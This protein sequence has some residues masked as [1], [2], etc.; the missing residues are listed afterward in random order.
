MS[1]QSHVQYTHVQSVTVSS[2]R[3]KA[4]NK[5]S[6]VSWTAECEPPPP[7]CTPLLQ[8]ST[9]RLPGQ[10]SRLREFIKSSFAGLYCPTEG[11]CKH[12][13][14]LPRLL[15]HGYLSMLY[16]SLS[17][18]QLACARLSPL[19]RCGKVV[20]R[21]KGKTGGSR[22]WISST[23]R[24]DTQEVWSRELE[25]MMCQIITWFQNNAIKITLFCNT[26]K[27]MF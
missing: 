23:E 18:V 21:E 6:F 17:E 24:G 13:V 27:K 1:L 9:K 19:E 14:G 25:E 10:Q 7:D 8:L 26:Q 3:H 15:I 16:H 11:P 20:E 2:P 5:T 22:D 12:S 4:Q